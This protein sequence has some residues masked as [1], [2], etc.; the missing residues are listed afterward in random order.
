MCGFPLRRISIS[1]MCRVPLR[2]LETN[3]RSLVISRF[4]NAFSAKVPCNMVFHAGQ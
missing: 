2:I 1:L 3:I 4:V